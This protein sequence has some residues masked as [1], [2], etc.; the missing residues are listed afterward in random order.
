[1]DQLKVSRGG[2]NWHQGFISGAS[3]SLVNSLPHSPQSLRSLWVC[4]GIVLFVNAILQNPEHYSVA[5]PG[6]VVTII[7]KWQPQIKVYR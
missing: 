5:S 4:P 2:G 7:I 6:W 1:M 3:Q